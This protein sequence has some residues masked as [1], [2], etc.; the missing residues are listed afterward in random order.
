MGQIP[1]RPESRGISFSYEG[2]VLTSFP[3]LLDPKSELDAKVI[4]R[5]V[6]DERIQRRKAFELSVHEVRE[7]RSIRFACP[8]LRGAVQCPKRKADIK[9]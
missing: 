2:M 7:D 4:S 5:E 1:K 8:A 9:A 6:F 3:D